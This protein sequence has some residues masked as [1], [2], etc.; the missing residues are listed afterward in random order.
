[1]VEENI[2]GLKYDIVH[3]F[4]IRLDLQW[5]LYMLENEIACFGYHKFGYACFDQS[6]GM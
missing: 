3:V 2:K 6:K 5:V 4:V 1:M